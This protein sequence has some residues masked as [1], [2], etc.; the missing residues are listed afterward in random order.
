MGVG[1]EGE[2]LLTVTILAIPF[3]PSSRWFTYPL[4]KDLGVERVNHSN[5]WA[6][7]DVRWSGVGG[8]LCGL[9]L[10]VAGEQ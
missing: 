1:V 5:V 10:V 9:N 7:L 6:V 8:K 3:P 2:R 4:S